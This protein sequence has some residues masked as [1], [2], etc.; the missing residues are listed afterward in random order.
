VKVLFPVAVLM[1]L[2]GLWT[3][4]CVEGLEMQWKNLCGIPEL[5]K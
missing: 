1:L 4:D 5:P 2:C 3:R